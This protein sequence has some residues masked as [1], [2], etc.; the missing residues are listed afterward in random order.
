VRT[1]RKSCKSA[2]IGGL[3]VTSFSVPPFTAIEGATK[4]G[5]GSGSA[6]GALRTAQA[7]ALFA[8]EAVRA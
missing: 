4:S 5:P 8:G 2:A 7:G 3:S 6:A 1:S